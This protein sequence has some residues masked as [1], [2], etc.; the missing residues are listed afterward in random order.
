M[1][2]EL[3]KTSQK[4]IIIA[5]SLCSIAV[6]LYF[7]LGSNNSA[8]SSERTISFSRTV[9]VGKKEIFDAM[10]DVNKYP[11]I[12]LDSFLS[13]NIINRTDSTIFAEEEVREAGVKTK[14]LVKHTIVPYQVHILEIMNGDAKGTTI[15]ETYEEAGNS[16]TILITDVNMTLKGPLSYFAYLEYSNIEH[17]INT[18][19]DDFVNYV[20][21]R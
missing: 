5:I 12:L 8:I 20:K 13:V 1:S 19:I 18:V 6:L 15:K 11:E 2:Y 17:A 14:L 7:V 10:A 16:S 3:D 21:N 4:K 9:D